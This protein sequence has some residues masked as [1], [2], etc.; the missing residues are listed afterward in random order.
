MNNIIQ[1]MFLWDLVTVF[2]SHS[3]EEPH[4]EAGFQWK[5]S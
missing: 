5:E 3:G 2:I 1:D 4:L